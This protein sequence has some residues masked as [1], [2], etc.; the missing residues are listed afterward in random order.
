MRSLQVGPDLPER[1]HVS[2]KKDVQKYRNIFSRADDDIFHP[3]AFMIIVDFSFVYDHS[4]F[5]FC[6]FAREASLCLYFE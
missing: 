5:Q 6:F 2:V 4:R 3:K 1:P